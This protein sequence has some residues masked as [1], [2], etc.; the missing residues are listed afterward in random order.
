MSDEID[1]FYVVLPS[2]TKGNSQNTTSNFTIDLPNQ[3][4]LSKGGWQCVLSEL[5]YP[6]SFFK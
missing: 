3:L 2:N 6:Q 4:D 1:D 5:T